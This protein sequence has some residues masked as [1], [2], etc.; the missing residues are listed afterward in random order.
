MKKDKLKEGIWIGIAAVCVCIFSIWIA[1][2]I[3]DY[4]LTPTPTQIEKQKVIRGEIVYKG[5]IITIILR[6]GMEPK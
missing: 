5:E 4:E 2:A 3:C 6:E 1:T